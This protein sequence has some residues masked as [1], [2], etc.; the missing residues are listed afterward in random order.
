MNCNPI[1]RPLFE[2]LDG[3]VTAGIPVM[4]HN[5]IYMSCILNFS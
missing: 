4:I 3:T 1:G 2:S 5:G